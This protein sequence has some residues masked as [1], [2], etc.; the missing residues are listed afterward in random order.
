MA[1]RAIVYARVSRDMTGEGRSTD[2]QIEACMKLADLREWE[3][4]DTFVD[5]SVS[6]YSGIDRPAWSDA[7]ARL[8]GGGIDVLIAWH[9]D[10]M[11]RSMLDLEELIGLCEQHDVGIA[12]ATGDIDLTTDVGRMV[13]R[14]LAAVAR[15]EVERKAARQRLANAARAERGLPHAGGPKVFGYEQDGVQIIPGEAD[16]IR[17][18]ADQILSGVPLATIARRWSERGFTSSMATLRQ[19]KNG[20]TGR[21]VKNVFVNPRH[22]GILVRHG[23][24]VGPGAW[25]PIL[26]LET[27]LALVAKLSDP[28]RTLGSV[29]TGRIPATLLTSIATC[30]HCGETV[31]GSSVRGALRYACPAARGFVPREEADAWVEGL[32]VGRLT[33]SNALDLLTSDDTD[34]TAPVREELGAIRER[35]SQA[36]DSL[37]AGVLSQARFDS[38]ATKLEVRESELRGR[39]THTGPSSLLTDAVMADDVQAFWDA[40]PLAERRSLVQSLFSKLELHS[41][42]RGLFDVQQAVKHE[43]ALV[44]TR[45]QRALRVVR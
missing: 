41:A 9:I 35:L 2:R 24:E 31:R 10:R 8:A 14:I 1:K 39:L 19:A 27:H 12:T 26:P 15:A 7:L 3:V 45:D 34:D 43:F 30:G 6:A 32:V 20:W 38:I 18:A 33:S 11:T 4:V 22:A 13:A 16:A 23:V 28:A 5:N 21:G 36:E 29:K 17:L 25:E 37:V 40:L 42:G 44:R